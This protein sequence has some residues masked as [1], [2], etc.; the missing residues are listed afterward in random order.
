MPNNTNINTNSSPANLKDMNGRA[1]VNSTN[2][3]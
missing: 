3:N 2:N 1:S